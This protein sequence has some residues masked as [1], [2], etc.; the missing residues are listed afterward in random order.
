M[1]QPKAFAT[2]TGCAGTAHT[3]PLNQHVLVFSINT[4]QEKSLLWSHWRPLTPKQIRHPGLERT[5]LKAE[6]AQDKCL[7]LGTGEE[8]G[9]GIFSR[10]C[11]YPGCQQYLL[12]QRSPL[13]PPA[14]PNSSCSPSPPVPQ[15]NA[16]N[17]RPLS[18]EQKRLLFFQ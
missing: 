5:A 1:H 18:K 2:T 17:Q 12:E 8:L 9:N 15:G 3:K 13:L 7:H 11:K 6:S 14:H 4:R 16:N 10:P